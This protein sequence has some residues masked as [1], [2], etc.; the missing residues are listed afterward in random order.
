[1]ASDS[2]VTTVVT[3]LLGGGGAAFVVSLAKSWS[4][5]RGGARARERETITDLAD[6]ADRADERERTAARDRDYWRAIAG[7]YHY[8][9]TS[10]G[11]NPDPQD[12]VQ[13]S[14]QPPPVPP[15]HR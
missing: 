11:T 8:Q 14:D 1:M 15:G 10:K 5:L 12:P 9:L 2:L 13:P 4:S 6:R 3:A 7:K